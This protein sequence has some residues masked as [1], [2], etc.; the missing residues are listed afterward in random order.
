MNWVGIAYIENNNKCVLLC[1]RD[2]YC[3]TL[4]SGFALMHIQIYWITKIWFKIILK[5]L[6]Q[7]NT[8][9]QSHFNTESRSYDA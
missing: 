2:L 8:M 6:L 5:L 7:L 3:L 9:R 1:G 4:S